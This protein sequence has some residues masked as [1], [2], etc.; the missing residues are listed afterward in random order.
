MKKITKKELARLEKKRKNKLW[1]EVR[2]KVIARDEQCI[3]CGSKNKLNV[4]HILEKEFLSFRYLQFDE[5]NLITV[6]PKC[7]KFS[8]FSM[9]KNPLFALTIFKAIY[10]NN[11]DFLLG[12]AVKLWNTRQKIVEKE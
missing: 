3:I 8:E 2:L 6:C 11:Y 10:P 12:E 7:H 4:H 1:K 5:R 9:H